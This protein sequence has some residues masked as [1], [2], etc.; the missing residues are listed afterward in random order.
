MQNLKSRTQGEGK[1]LQ[2]KTCKKLTPKKMLRFLNHY[3]K[4]TM[5]Y[6]QNKKALYIVSHY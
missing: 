3:K 4:H 1:Y 2:T 6:L 5:L